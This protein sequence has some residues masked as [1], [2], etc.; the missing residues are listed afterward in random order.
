MHFTVK[1]NAFYFFYHIMLWIQLSHRYCLTNK[2]M[3]TL[4]ELLYFYLSVFQSKKNTVEIE[5]SW[6]QFSCAHFTTPLSLSQ[7]NKKFY[8]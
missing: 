3:N 6:E 1:C 4:Q 7:Y 2:F 5:N 8:K